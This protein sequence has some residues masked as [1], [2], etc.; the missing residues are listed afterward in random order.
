MIKQLTFDGFEL[1]DYCI[2]RSIVPI[3]PSINNNFWELDHVDGAHFRNSKHQ[4]LELQVKIT[5]K[6]PIQF[7]LDELKKILYVREPKLLI[8]HDSPERGLMCKLNGNVAFTSRYRLADATLNFVS[9]NAY[10]VSTEGTK[11]FTA[12]SKGFINID[13]G[14]TASTPP[15][16]DITFNSDNGYLGLVSRDKFITLGN[17]QEL[18]KVDVPP[19]EKALNEEMHHLDGWTRI[20]N[21]QNYVTDYNKITSL[22]KAKHDQYGTLIDSSSFTGLANDW[23]GHAYIK[24][25]HQGELDQVAN[26]FKL[27]SRITMKDLQFEKHATAGLLIVVLDENNNPIVTTSVYDA[28]TD[29]KK[30]ATSFKVNSFKSGDRKHSKIIH[31]GSLSALEGYIEMEKMGNRFNFVIHTDSINVTPIPLK[32]GDYV[33]IKSSAT[34]AETGHRIKEDY[35]GK[36]YYIAGSKTTNGKLSYRLDI[37]GW[38]IY[39]VYATDIVEYNRTTTTQGTKQIKHTVVDNN[40]AQMQ[41]SKVLIWQGVWGATQ[42]YSNF[43]LTSV[44]VDRLYTDKVR[45]IVNVFQKGDTLQVNNSTGQIIHNGL[46][47]QGFVDVDSRFFELDYGG[48]QVQVVKSK[49]ASFP[50]VKA[51]IEERYL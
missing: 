5:I 18:D 3:A 11:T 51:T 33:H 42:P 48:T 38:P 32:N 39:W 50:V 23:Q 47:F 40:L 30:L 8:D 19:T 6:E 35:K 28:S 4:K 31:N 34:H 49:W 13:N 25:F 2:I 15:I 7:N 46:P 24:P 12:D 26:N 37:D 9:P 22:G 16:F 17:P 14:G 43:N 29:Q 41:P 27:K 20:T 45:D 36:T 10:W 44:V 1:S 21:V